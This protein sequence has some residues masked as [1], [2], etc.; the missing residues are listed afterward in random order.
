MENEFFSPATDKVWI[1]TGYECKIC[2]TTGHFD[3][4]P[5]RTTYYEHGKEQERF[6]KN[7]DCDGWQDDLIEKSRPV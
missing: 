3:E 2:G 1:I 5:T 6:C 4:F 7:P